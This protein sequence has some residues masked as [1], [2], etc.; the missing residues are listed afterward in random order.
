[1]ASE[2]RNQKLPAKVPTV[3]QTVAGCAMDQVR[4]PRCEPQ[5]RNARERLLSSRPKGFPTPT[6]AQVGNCQHNAPF[7]RRGRLL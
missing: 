3:L 2:A 5:L 7:L 4:A 6:P 1:M